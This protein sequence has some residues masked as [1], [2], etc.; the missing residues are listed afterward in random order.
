MNIYNPEPAIAPWTAN[1]VD[2]S[3]RPWDGPGIRYNTVTV[4]ELYTLP[5]STTP[6]EARGLWL[7]TVDTGG[8]SITVRPYSEIAENGN[9]SSYDVTF[10]ITGSASRIFPFGSQM[11]VAATGVSDIVWFS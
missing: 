3:G 1:R 11:V 2:T 5:N 8:G 10:V 6:E 7:G 9:P 4:G